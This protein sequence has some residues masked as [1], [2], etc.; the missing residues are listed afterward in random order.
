MTVNEFF[1]YENI[2]SDNPFNNVEVKQDYSMADYKQMEHYALMFTFSQ[3]NAYIPLSKEFAIRF[4]IMTVF[5][6]L[7]LGESVDSDNLFKCIM[8]T[9]IYNKFIN[10]FPENGAD[11]VNT[12]REGLREAIDNYDRIHNANND[13]LLTFLDV[14]D[15]IVTNEK[16]VE[17]AEALS[18]V[19]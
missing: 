14:F 3:D 5:L 9:D 13:T 16:F 18:K 12:I 4:S 19:E 7:D 17:L 11:M 1:N 10:L 2:H 8:C 15:K 6:N